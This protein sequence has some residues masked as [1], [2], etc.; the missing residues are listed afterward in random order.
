[1]ERKSQLYL[2]FQEFI[3]SKIVP[4][5]TSH[6]DEQ[7]STWFKVVVKANEMKV[8]WNSEEVFKATVPEEED[9]QGMITRICLN[10][11]IGV[12]FKDTTVFCYLIEGR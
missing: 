12:I 6:F 2:C 7:S 4:E 10:N 5:L 9:F 3:K 8:L 11:E 1:M